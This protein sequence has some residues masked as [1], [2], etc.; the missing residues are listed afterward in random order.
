MQHDIMGMVLAANDIH[1]LFCIIRDVYWLEYYR[2]YISV[3][4]AVL[5][6]IWYPTILNIITFTRSEINHKSIV[7]VAEYVLY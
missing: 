3:D 2:V 1:S 7:V 5:L 4:R 6:F